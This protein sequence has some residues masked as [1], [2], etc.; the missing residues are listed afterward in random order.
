MKIYNQDKTQELL[1]SEIDS[2]LGR[3][4][5]DKLFVAHHEAVAAIKGKTA[6]EYAREYAAQGKVTREI[7]GKL[8]VVTKSYAHGEDVEEIIDA[9]DIPAQE[10]YDEYEDIQIYI[11]Y[12]AEELEERK[13]NRL[14]E[15]R[16]PLLAAFDKWEKAVLRGREEDDEKVMAWYRA[17]LDLD[18]N[19]LEEMPKRVAYYL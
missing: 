18:E 5:A 1:E 12:S 14:R 7:D 19:A 11:P 9:P 13:N 15:K 10:A 16:L 3:L 2:T 8:Y 6:Q 4:V 17:I